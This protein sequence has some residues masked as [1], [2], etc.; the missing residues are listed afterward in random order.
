M[1]YKF[2]LMQRFYFSPYVCI[3]WNNISRQVSSQQ[4]YSTSNTKINFL[5]L[6]LFW[7]AENNK[8]IYFFIYFYKILNW[9][10]A[11]LKIFKLS[12]NFIW[13]GWFFIHYLQDTSNSTCYESI[14]RLD[15]VH[16]SCYHKHKKH[17]FFFTNICI[18]SV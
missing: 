5:T 6:P 3:N 17:I 10:V 11:F 12:I 7:N 2:Y 1:I 9:F 18:K 15:H 14:I 8:F 13:S 16:V 4:K